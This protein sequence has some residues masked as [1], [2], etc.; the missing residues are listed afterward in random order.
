MSPLDTLP[1]T[2]SAPKLPGTIL[3]TTEVSPEWKIHEIS[4]EILPLQHAKHL[5]NFSDNFGAGWLDPKN[6]QLRLQFH[7]V[8]LF[9]NAKTDELWLSISGRDEKIA[10]SPTCVASPLVGNRH[11]QLSWSGQSR[12]V[13]DE[14]IKLPDWAISAAKFKLLARVA[15]KPE[16]VG[17]IY[18]SEAY[19]SIDESNSF[20]GV[21]DSIPTRVAE[22]AAGAT[23][24][25]PN[26]SIRVRGFVDR[27]R[28]MNRLFLFTV[29]LPTLLSTV[30]FG[31]IA[32]DVYISE[33]EFIVRSPD[34]QTASPLGM[35]LKGTEFSS[36]QN[37][38]YSVQNYILS[39]DAL[40]VLVEQL[41]INKAFSNKDVDIFSRF[42]GLDWDNSFEALHKYYQ[43]KVDVQLDSTSS[44]IT[45]DTRA[46]TAEDSYRMNQLLLD[47]S[48]ALV[49]KLNERA[50]QDMIGFASQE[51][52]MAEI[53]VKEAT[54]SLARIQTGRTK[55]E[56]RGRSLASRLTEYQRMAL[57]KEFADKMLANGMSS[58]EDARNQ[59]L[60]K[61][62]YLERIAQPSKPD[63]AIEPRRIRNILATILLGLIIWG[64]LSILVAGVEEHH[65]R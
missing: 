13:L 47:M 54:L 14:V 26:T 15:G 64:I 39:R 19:K 6:K 51:V 23:T 40:R 58:L 59:A 18:V 17:I 29:V 37:D 5:E 56:E 38:S 32:S 41:G 27:I 11:P 60:R 8:V 10:L 57:D 65:D 45:L 44:I 1:P 43:K 49:N 12:F 52:A 9:G 42:A 61:Q 34:Q 62:L 31:L 22:L 30:Y 28:E 53:K 50:R 35:I 36:S 7:L 4:V 63:R 16:K 33:S 46:F 55:V 20:P 25:N 48:E 3:S 21:S 2:H 24:R